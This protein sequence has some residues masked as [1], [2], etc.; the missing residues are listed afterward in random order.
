[1]NTTETIVT[2]NNDSVQPT[3]TVTHQGSC[4][5]GAVRFQVTADLTRGGSRCN[6]S[7]CTKIGGLGVI[8]A[9]EALRVLSP[10]E[11]LGEYVW[12]ANISRRYFCKRC[13]IHTF[14]R[15]HLAELGG[16]FAGVNLNT[17][18]DIDSAQLG[19][20]YWDG[21]HNN[22]MAGTRPT[23]WPILPASRDAAA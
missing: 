14:S 21:R 22:W 18:D 13:G 20:A 3:S 6:C 23:P 7:I 16:A 12:G 11:E 1:M 19:V 8:V 17:L 2:T 9:P 5:C 10:E 15:G 4:H